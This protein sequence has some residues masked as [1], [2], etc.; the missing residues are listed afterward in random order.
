MK[1]HIDCL[2]GFSP[3]LL[4]VEGH[5]EQVCGTAAALVEGTGPWPEGA[6][7]VS[8]NTLIF[9]H[10]MTNCK[11][12]Y[13]Y[14]TEEVA[15]FITI[16]FPGINATTTVAQGQ[17]GLSLPLGQLFINAWVDGKALAGMTGSD[18]MAIG[19]P[20]G[21]AVN[22]Q[23][24]KEEFLSAQLPINVGET[25]GP[26]MMQALVLVKSLW[27]INEVDFSF[28]VQLGIMF[29]WTDNS[30]WTECN[31]RDEEINMG[32]CKYVWRPSVTY[33]NAREQMVISEQLIADPTTKTVQYIVDVTATVDAPMSFRNFPNDKQNLVLRIG[34][35]L[36]FNRKDVMFGPTNA[37]LT[38]VTDI[39]GK[40]QLSGWELRS[41]SSK[42]T[43]YQFNFEAAT[44]RQGPLHEYMEFYE[45][46]AKDAGIDAGDNL[47]YST[48]EVVLEVQRVKAFY[49][50]NYVV[51]IVVL[52]A[53]SWTV[54]IVQPS[55]LADRCQIALALVLALNVYQLILNDTMPKTPY[56]TPM[57]EY[58]IGSTF[59][60]VSTCL[61]SVLV[62]VC[63]KRAAV[64]EAALEKFQRLGVRRSEDG[65]KA[66]PWSI[67]HER[68]KSPGDKEGGAN[69]VE[70]F[71]APPLS[72]DGED[73]EK[74]TWPWGARAVTPPPSPQNSSRLAS[75]RRRCWLREVAIAT[76]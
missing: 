10:I 19:M 12:P 1:I 53:L 63:Q 58:I 2:Y 74:G 21:L 39:T 6:S 64:R 75:S 22:F 20:A 7:S 42:E 48:V 16:L 73:A 15:Q 28:S 43:P 33:M 57:H 27:D 41:V 44:N 4:R 40:D 61:E 18:L 76:Y 69:V 59:F 71:T 35:T 45:D 60:I 34:Q 5:G 56:L 37:I 68:A 65:V 47:M 30:L 23:N 50:A 72:R 13:E 25:T 17:P 51:L 62:A 3:A 32:S 54:F 38:R 11:H 52:T 9:S 14:S 24:E 55:D 8:M 49:V 66:S 36:S 46:Q 26:F 29:V 31:G 70:A 67:A